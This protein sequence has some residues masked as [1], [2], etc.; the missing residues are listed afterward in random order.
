MGRDS[1]DP[2]HPREV[3]PSAE[4]SVAGAGEHDNPDGVID[5]RGRQGI[6]QSLHD[7]E[8]HRIATVGPIDRDARDSAGLVLEFAHPRIVGNSDVRTNALAS[9]RR[10]WLLVLTV[11]AALL[12]VL[13]TF[14]S[15]S[16]LSELSVSGGWMLAGGLGMQVALEFVE[17]PKDDIGTVGYGLLMASFALILAFCLTNL[18]TWGFGVIAIGIAMN[19][20]VIGLNQGMPTIPIGNDADGNRIPKPIELSVKH[21]PEEPDDLLRFLDDRILLPEPF[22]AVVSFGDLVVSVGICELAYFASRRRR[23]RGTARQSSTAS[24]PRRANTSS[25]APSTRPS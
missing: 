20:L 7:L 21:R 12:V 25:R 19:A 13:V 3:G 1:I 2:A 10:V 9:V 4:G 16:Q 22:D 8:R 14:G 5:T 17:I 23:R 24:S 15:F 6:A 18:R 11:V